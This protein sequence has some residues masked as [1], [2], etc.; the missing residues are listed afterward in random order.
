MVKLSLKK[1]REGE[2]EAKEM[3]KAAKEVYQQI[4]REAEILHRLRFWLEGKAVVCL[5]LLALVGGC[6]TCGGIGRLIQDIGTDVEYIATGY[7]G[8]LEKN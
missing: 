4:V 1:V 6:T 5:V 3:A 7:E 2:K 8:E